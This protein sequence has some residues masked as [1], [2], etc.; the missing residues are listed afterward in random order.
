MRA[1]SEWPDARADLFALALEVRCRWALTR[2]YD[3][4]VTHLR[5]C[6]ALERAVDALTRAAGDA[7]C[8][9]MLADIPVLAEAYAEGV[10]G[11]AD[12][13]AEQEAERM[14]EAAEEAERAR[15]EALLARNDWAALH[16]PTPEA[17]TERLL[18]GAVQTVCEHHLHYEDDVL[19]V[20]NPY[21]VDGAL[22][23]A[24]DVVQMRGFLANMAR[25]VTYGLTP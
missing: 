4:G 22:G 19:W 12:W 11:W 23:N 25:Q 18:A 3:E 6:D 1:T 17:L 16:L 15:V 13:R 5:C 7:P 9:L 24:P 21:G 8:P 14:A 2:V 10:Q 20:T